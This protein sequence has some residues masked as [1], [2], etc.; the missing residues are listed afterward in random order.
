MPYQSQQPSNDASRVA[1]FDEVLEQST[2][3]DDKIIDLIEALESIDM[4]QA[5]AS[6]NVNS[7]ADNNGG[8]IL[9]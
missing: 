7:M 4:H 8:R 1:D 9:F 5:T 3:L 2:E 6:L